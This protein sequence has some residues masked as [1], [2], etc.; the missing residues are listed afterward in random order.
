MRTLL[1]V[2]IAT[3]GPGSY[4]RDGDEVFIRCNET[5]VKSLAVDTV[6]IMPGVEDRVA[7]HAKEKV[8]TSLHP[9]VIDLREPYVP[10]TL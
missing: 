10:E 9:R 6:V 4:Y 7:N 8:R 5:S 3:T 2:P 1:V